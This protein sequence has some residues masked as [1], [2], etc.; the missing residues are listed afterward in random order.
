MSTA[1]DIPVDYLRRTGWKIFF[2]LQFHQ[3]EDLD[4]LKGYKFLNEL[5]ATA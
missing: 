3:S 5:S 1:S 4:I 2:F